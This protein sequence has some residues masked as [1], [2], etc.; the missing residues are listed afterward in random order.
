MKPKKK[1]SCIKH[2]DLGYK[3][4]QKSLFSL[5]TVLKTYYYILTFN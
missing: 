2:V 4:G 5:K 3:S 1:D